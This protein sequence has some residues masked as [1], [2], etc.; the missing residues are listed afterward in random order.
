M[1]LH[2]IDNYLHEHILK[3]IVNND[4]VVLDTFMGTGS[5]GVA[6]KKLECNYIGIE[7]EHTYFKIAEE[8]INT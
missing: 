3:N 8:R 6:C 2:P 1:S 7:L 4:S 5:I